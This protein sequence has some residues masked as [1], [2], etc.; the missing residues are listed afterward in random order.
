[1]NLD[2][3]SA[4]LGALLAIMIAVGVS[5]AGDWLIRWLNRKR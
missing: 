1:M 4:T 3:E 5:L 2:Y